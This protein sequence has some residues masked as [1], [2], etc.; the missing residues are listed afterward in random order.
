MSKIVEFAQIVEQEIEINRQLAEVVYK[1]LQEEKE[2]NKEFRRRLIQL[3][4]DIYPD[5]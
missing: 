3:L 4:D 5:Y 2:K 1:E